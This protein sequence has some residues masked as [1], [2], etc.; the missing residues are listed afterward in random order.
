MMDQRVIIVEGDPDSPEP[1][2]H[3][4]PI[5]EFLLRNGNALCD[6]ARQ[7][8][9]KGFANSQGGWGCC[10][11]Q[12]IDFALVEARFELPSTVH[13]RRDQDSIFCER[14]WISIDGGRPITTKGLR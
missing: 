4:A 14:T 5:V 3:L 6:R 7:S 1:Y 12:P 13:L 11:A 10:L 9:N 2:V 8:R